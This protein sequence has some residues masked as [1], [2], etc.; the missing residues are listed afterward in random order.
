MESAPQKPYQSLDHGRKR[1][2]ADCSFVPEIDSILQALTIAL[3]EKVSNTA[4]HTH[5]EKQPVRGC[6]SEEAGR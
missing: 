3:R 4:Y 1:L 6:E 2:S 5:H